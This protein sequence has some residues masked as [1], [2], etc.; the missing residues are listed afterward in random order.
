[1]NTICY[2]TSYTIYS[3][4]RMNAIFY[5]ICCTAK[6]RHCGGVYYGR[7]YITMQNSSRYIKDSCTIYPSYG[8][9]VHPFSFLLIW[10][11]VNPV[12]GWMMW[13]A[14][15]DRGSS[16]KRRFSMWGWGMI[17]CRECI[18]KSSYS[19]MSISIRRSE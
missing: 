7:T 15:S 9:I 8:Y 3:F 13:G 16:T 12:R 17:S 2:E 18:T 6:V 10:V 11:M 5:L 19:R 14:I 4:P 1:M